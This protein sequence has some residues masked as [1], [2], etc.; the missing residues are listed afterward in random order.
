MPQK[1]APSPHPPFAIG[2][3]VAV[4]HGAYSTIRLAPR[5]EAIADELREIVPA[6]SDSDEPTVRLL[7]ITLAQVEAATLYVAETGIVDSKG[8]PA[9]ILRHMGTMLNTAARLC[10]RLGLTPTSRASLG[11][12]LVRTEDALA[13]HLDQGRRIREAADRRLVEAEQ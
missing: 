7:A 1:Q 5:A 4:L 12:D 9:P 11:L 6:R 10:D 8:T 2:N 3:T 13:Q